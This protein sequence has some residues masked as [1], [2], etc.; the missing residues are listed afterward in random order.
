MSARATG[1]GK[2]K[3]V[4]GGNSGPP[5]TLHSPDDPSRTPSAAASATPDL[6]RSTILSLIP[7][8]TIPEDRKRS[9]IVEIQRSDFTQQSTVEYFIGVVGIVAYESALKKSAGFG[10][11]GLAGSSD[12]LS[13]NPSPD[14]GKQLL[15]K[16]YCHGGDVAF[17]GG[18][19]LEFEASINNALFGHSGSL[20]RKR[21]ITVDSIQGGYLPDLAF[22][23]IE[24][25]LAKA[26]AK[27]HDEPMKYNPR[28]VASLQRAVGIMLMTI[29]QQ[30]ACERRQSC[31]ST[32]D[33]MGP[34]TAG[35]FLGYT[36]LG[37]KVSLT[38]LLSA[39]Q[40]MAARGALPPQFTRNWEPSV[41]ARIVQLGNY[42]VGI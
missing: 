2:S 5:S 39:I 29:L 27:R 34:V 10:V 3:S 20:K 23:A 13:V 4:N 32:A 12:P 37:S 21:M 28:Y 31:S 17:F 11:A 19:D 38:H 15:A 14:K 9:L 16:A 36:D 40:A 26:L 42:H 8:M 7:Q 33:E 6:V 30:T 18:I 1:R 22:A 41:I 25:R 35:S 24:A